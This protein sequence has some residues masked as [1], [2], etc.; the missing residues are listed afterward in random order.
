[1][2]KTN[3][4]RCSIILMFILVCTA[5]KQEPDNNFGSRERRGDG[6][7][8][9]TRRK[10]TKEENEKRLETCGKPLMNKPEKFENMWFGR[11]GGG[12]DWYRYGVVLISEYHAIASKKAADFT[13]CN[14]SESIRTEERKNRK[15]YFS[16]T[17][18][19]SINDTEHRLLT[20]SFIGDCYG[21]HTSTNDGIEILEFEEKVDLPYVCVWS[22][23][24]DDISPYKTMIPARYKKVD[25]G[26]YHEKQYGKFTYW[27]FT[28]EEL[29]WFSD[30]HLVIPKKSN[31]M[32]MPIL[33]ESE[34]TS[35]I[36]MIDSFDDSTK[37]FKA[38][39]LL[40]Y[41]EEICES[42]GI[43]PGPP[44]TT[45]IATTPTTTTT[46]ATTTTEL[47]LPTTTTT[48][49]VPE[50][51]GD[52][53]MMDFEMPFDGPLVKRWGSGAECLNLFV[54]FVFSVLG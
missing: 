20:A 29:V 53:E 25:G 31:D 4:I 11:Y 21:N 13:Q 23:S 3:I 41:L 2:N 52:P 28:P 18:S 46:T 43:C 47:Q 30:N 34:R 32:S 36:A 8:V 16:L 7:K 27:D 9:D 26:P 24:F 49:Y 5:E 1:M 14:K 38:T 6:D 42:F 22:T 12:A 37:L 39:L 17:G 35:V 44:T 54:V 15:V 33:V 48:Y 10:L 45:T 40:P 51:L 50:I 19:P